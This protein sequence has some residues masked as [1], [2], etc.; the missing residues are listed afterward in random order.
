[1]GILARIFQPSAV[2]AAEGQYRPGPWLVDDGWIPASWGKYWNWWQ[3]GYNPLPLHT[4]S[5]M[6]EAC[7]S[8]YSQTVAMCPGSHWQTQSDGGRVRVETSALNRI[9]RK[10]NAYQSISDFLLNLTRSL[11]LDGN[12]YAVAIRNARFEISELHLFQKGAY[13]IAETG[14]VFYGLSGNEVIERQLAPELLS[15]VPARDVLHVRLQTPRHPLKGETPLMVC[16]LDVAANNAMLAQQL[17]FYANQARP[18]YVLTTDQVL[19]K[20]QVTEIRDRW[21]EHAQGLNQG[22]TPILSSGLKPQN[23]SQTAQD[24]QLADM[25][26]LTEQHVA[27]AYRVPLPI[28]GIGTQTYS[29]TELLMQQWVAQ[30]LGFVLNH[31]EE[32]FGALFGLRGQPDEYLEL[33]TEALLRSSFKERIEA[34]ARGV[35]GGIFS[36]NEA[37]RREGYPDAEGGDE[38]R[39]Q[40]QVVP[41]SFGA[42]MQPTPPAAP[43]PV[44]EPESEPEPEPEADDESDADAKEWFRRELLSAADEHARRAA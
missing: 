12:A 37:R 33:D 42:Q 17:T 43:V 36:P 41:L 22:G 44:A 31:I 16:A 11:Y 6:V 34:L 30:G 32:A 10:P 18:S 27:L 35:Q 2:K 21:N 15:A 3:S 28:L 29:S 19:N 7:V 25:L 20:V 8:A 1:M 38:P 9:L 13:L 5:A 39:V 26:K 23:L 14:D 24:A 40:Q 4:S